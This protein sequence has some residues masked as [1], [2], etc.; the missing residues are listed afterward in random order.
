MKKPL[1]DIAPMDACY[2][3]GFFDGEGC[4]GIYER[5]VANS[6]TGAVNPYCS[7]SVSISNTNYE[8]LAHIK[9]RCG[10]VIN[11][12]SQNWY[13]PLKNGMPRKTLWRWS[14]QAREGAHLLKAML[15][16]L[17]VKRKQ[18]LVGLEYYAITSM[19]L[20]QKHPGV[21]GRP[22]LSKNDL[23]KRRELMHKIKALKK[24]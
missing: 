19:R 4:V 14:A 9:K 21:Y 23:K 10:G 24:Q 17:I 11:N 2:L 20:N 1:I 6:G 13:P 8:V 7:L 12:S 22:P 16:F 3:A 5:S 18:A 15:P